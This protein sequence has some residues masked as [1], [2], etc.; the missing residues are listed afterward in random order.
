MLHRLDTFVLRSVAQ[1]LVEV[2]QRDPHWL[3]KQTV[4]LYAILRAIETVLNDGSFIHWLSV[5]TTMMMALAVHFVTRD[6]LKSVASDFLL[7]ILFLFGTSSLFVLSMVAFFFGDYQMTVVFLLMTPMS[8]L[9]IYFLI[10]DMP[11]P[12]PKKEL[13]GRLVL[14]H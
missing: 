14:D 3:A 11:T 4:T 6:I 10:C 7:R 2:F 8:S 13:K 5:V 12:K 9:W 1:P